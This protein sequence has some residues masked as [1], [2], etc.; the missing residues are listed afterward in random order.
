[1]N[2]LALQGS[3][4][5]KGNTSYFLNIILEEI[6]NAGIDTK[7]VHVVDKNIKPCI[8]CFSCQKQGNYKCAISDDFLELAE[9]IKMADLI[10]LASP[11]YWF[12]ITGFLKTVIDRFY[13]LVKF[14]RDAGR[15]K[16]QLEGKG[17]A[18]VITAGSDAFSGADLIVQSFIRIAEFCDMNYLG[19]I[20][21]YGIN[22]I[23]DIKNNNTLIKDARTFANKLLFNKSC[24]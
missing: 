21:A 2:I 4:R 13:C 1:M 11:V 6:R 18:I 12:G 3:P 7:T 23:D 5:K 8:S 14:D 19:T 22:S 15:I 10:V 20:G 16:S 24:Y 17:L 9:N